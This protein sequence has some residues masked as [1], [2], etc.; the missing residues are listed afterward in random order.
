MYNKYENDTKQNIFEKPI[1]NNLQNTYHMDNYVYRKCFR[2]KAQG[3]LIP[4][5]HASTQ[6]TQPLKNGQNK[7]LKTNLKCLDQKEHRNRWYNFQCEFFYYCIWATVQN[8]GFKQK[9][10]DSP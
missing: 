5:E 6:I 2:A 1:S 8:F 9:S 7:I 3:T 10:L 4:S